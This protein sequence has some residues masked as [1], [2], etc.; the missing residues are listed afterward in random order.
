M[1]VPRLRSGRQ[2]RGAWCASKDRLG[3]RASRR[4]SRPGISTASSNAPAPARTVLRAHQALGLDDPTAAEAPSSQVVRISGSAR[5]N[6]RNPQAPRALSSTDP[7]VH[8]SLMIRPLDSPANERRSHADPDLAPGVGPATVPR[9]PSTTAD[10]TPSVTEHGN[11]QDS[12]HGAG[13]ASFQRKSPHVATG[14]PPEQCLDRRLRERNASSSSTIL[15][16]SKRSPVSRL[17]SHG[18]QPSSRVRATR[19]SDRR[20]SRFG[21]PRFARRSPG[22]PLSRRSDA[23]SRRPFPAG[24]D[25]PGRRWSSLP[26]SPSETVPRDRA[27]W[28]RQGSTCALPYGRSRGGAPMTAA[29]IR[30]LAQAA[31]RSGPG[32]MR[33]PV[34]SSR[35]PTAQL[36]HWGLPFTRYTE[37]GQ[38]RSH[39]DDDPRRHRATDCARRVPVCR[40]RQRGRPRPLVAASA[41]GCD[42]EGAPPSGGAAPR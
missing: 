17:P 4:R 13:S 21:G 16:A 15:V 3:L 40:R 27:N 36:Q 30:L 33:P 2:G 12:P 19:G 7:D 18:S 24:V 1:T 37:M 34:S 38:P 41:C 39:Q 11:R 23:V 29:C 28:I 22:A 9:P 10:M 42:E 31:A 26:R 6:S 14:L 35:F 5:Q 25:S 8:D 20:P 32:L